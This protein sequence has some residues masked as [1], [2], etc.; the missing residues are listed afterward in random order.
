MF[1]F[2]FLILIIVIPVVIV[3]ILDLFLFSR[4]FKEKKQNGNAQI[5]SYILII[6]LI[7]IYKNNF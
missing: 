2:I 5:I 1:D 6:L 4:L 7:A 3:K